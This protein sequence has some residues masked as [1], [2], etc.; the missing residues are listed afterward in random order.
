MAERIFDPEPQQK[1][2]GALAGCPGREAQSQ[3]RPIVRITRCSTHL[4]DRDNLWGSV[5]P[6]LDSLRDSGLIAGDD[7]ASIQLE[8]CQEKVK[9]L[10]ERGTIVEID[11]YPL[12]PPPS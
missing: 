5:K 4:L 7:E 1:P 10:A 6:L 8:V 11:L 12:V 9:H 2:L 3:A